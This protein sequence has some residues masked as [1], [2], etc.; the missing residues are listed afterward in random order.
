MSGLRISIDL[1]FPVDAVWRALTESRLVGEWF[2]PTDLAPVPGAY[3][4]FPPPG[5]SGFTGPFTID[6]VEVVALQ[7]LLLRFQ[8]EMLHADVEWRLAGAP[9]GSRLVVIQTGFLGLDGESRRAEILKIGRAS[10]RE[11]VL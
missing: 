3:R 5:L 4:A 1:P 8:G 7:R 2:F 11:R 9:G 6:V 10:C